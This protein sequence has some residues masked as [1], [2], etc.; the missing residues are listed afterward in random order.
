MNGEAKKQAIHETL[1]LLEAEHGRLTPDL[2]VKEAAK[3]TSPLHGEFEWND[4]KAAMAFRV[5]QARALIQRHHFYVESQKGIIVS[6]AWIRDPDAGTNEQGYRS[7]VSLR[8]DRDKAMDA[9]VTEVS[10]AASHLQRVRNLAVALELEGEVDEIM[11][12]FEVFRS[13]VEV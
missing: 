9:L 5:E 8:S 13:R 7:V 10:R 1:E 11:E 2:I 4:K 3:K 12:R 6:P